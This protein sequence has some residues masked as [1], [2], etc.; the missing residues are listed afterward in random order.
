M[1]IG[2]IY[3][4]NIS[5]TLHEGVEKQSSA[6]VI[7]FRNVSSAD[8]CTLRKMLQQK[9]AKVFMARNSLARVG[10]KSTIL[11]PITDNLDGQTLF[12][13]T[14]ADPVDIAKLLIKFAEKD[15]NFAIRGAV[16][17]GQ[18]LKKDDI[19]RL[20]D[21]PAKE[22]LIAQLLGTLQSPI[23]RLARTLNG[24]T[25]ELLSILKQISEKMEGN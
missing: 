12:V 16:V 17:S 10:L 8:V 1:K 21:L 25:V 2:K 11:A 6:F 18:L 5:K 23:T 9:Q 3:R 7:N 13:W 22:V 19:K 20:S 24:K 4:E 14:N 15:V